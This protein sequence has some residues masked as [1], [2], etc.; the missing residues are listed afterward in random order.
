MTTRSSNSFKGISSK[1][2]FNSVLSDAMFFEIR[3]GQWGYRRD[4]TNET[5]ALSY[6]DTTTRIVS[7]AAQTA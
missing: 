2:E 3:G 4:F 6:E 1:I 7:G 5:T